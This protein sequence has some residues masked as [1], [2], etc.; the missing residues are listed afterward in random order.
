[1]ASPSR[2]AAVW[3]PPNHRT[4]AT[5]IIYLGGSLG[6]ALGFLLG[7]WLVP[8]S[9]DVPKLLWTEAVLASLFCAV[10]L[11]FAPDR[12]KTPPSQ[13]IVD[14]EESLLLFSGST[15][16]FMRRS[17]VLFQSVSVLLLV[18]AGGLEAGSSGAWS[19]VLTQILPYSS[20]FV[21]WCGFANNIGGIFGI[22]SSGYIG[23]KLFQGRLKLLLLLFFAG[24]VCC[25]LWFTLQLKAPLYSG[26]PPIPPSRLNILAAS[27]LAGFFQG[28]CDPLFYELCAEITYPLPE[29]M[30]AGFITFA[31]NAA[32]LIFFFVAPKVSTDYIN[33]LTTASMALA[34]LLALAAKESY[35]RSLKDAQGRNKRLQ[36]N[37]EEK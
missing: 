21:G 2:V 17:A 19:G 4:S 26:G 30:S 10:A 22:F 15:R 33:T 24:N 12:P 34:M 23:D 18:V 13:A 32:S 35:Q 37:E 5:S 14:A 29:G 8:H 31:S 36:I 6:S 7:P 25:Y 16:E 27:T 11:L 3:F 9:A 28:G 20:S 1:M